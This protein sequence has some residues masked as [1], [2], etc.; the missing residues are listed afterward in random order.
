[1]PAG[2]I[3]VWLRGGY[4]NQTVPFMLDDRDSG[5]I[6][7]PIVYSAFSGEQVYITGAR[8]L[9][10]SWFSLVDATS[11]VWSRLDSAAQG[12]VYAV[13]LAAHGIIDYG[14]LKP[15][16]FNIN[17]IAPLELFI[18]G[19]PMTLARWPNQDQ[20]LT[21]SISVPS[22]T[23]ITY[24]GSR[25]ERWTLAPEVWFHGLWNTTYADFHLKAASINTTSKTITF[26]SAPPVFG[27]GPNQPYYAYNLLEEIDEPGEYYMDRTSGILYCWPVAPLSGATIQVSMVEG[28]LL[29]LG[30]TEYV[31]LSDLTIEATRGP[32][33][34]INGGDDNTV[35]RCL[36]RN[37]GEYAALVSGTSN[38][39][40]QCDIVDCGE[41]GVILRGGLRSS[42]IAG[43]NFATNCRICRVGRINW[44]NH[45]AIN[46]DSGCGNLASHNLI[47]EL[48]HSGVLFSGNNHVIEYNE[49][50]R[51][52]LV[53]SDAAAI[54]SGRDWGYRGNIIRYNF[55][56]HI[57]SDLGGRG[58][59]GILLDDCMSSAQ[60]FGNIFYKVSDIAIVCG[61]GRD[62]IM[63]NNLIA[64]CGIGHYGGDYARS[65][66]NNIPG[67]SFNLLERL[68]ADGI[69]YQQ[70]T[71]S[72][73][74]PSDS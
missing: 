73:A 7:K 9:D 37:G 64:L 10:P 38:G 22:S 39:L 56:H 55:I 31:K 8:T 14:T 53:T 40:D 65:E 59:N 26:A 60:I 13:N 19:Q 70:A 45:P 71:W 50:R 41:D 61:G 68:A 48:P 17:T 42:L 15:G 69:Q 20:P 36:F 5:T 28:S 67:S 47:D 23:Q 58:T 72:S 43:N 46:L 16:G 33:L 4:Y 62:N 18:A 49:I 27:I 11:P 51:T 24:S 74:Y 32:L 29:I 57:Q 54:Y 25:P 63:T 35:L 12:H 52:C 2:G 6:D 1:L 30:G 34:Q 44:S 3:T 66:I 21:R